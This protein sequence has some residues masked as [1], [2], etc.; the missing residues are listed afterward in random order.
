MLA[1]PEPVALEHRRARHRGAGD[2]V[3]RFHRLAAGRRA[4][5]APSAAA[6]ARARSRRA[7]P[8]RRPR[9]RETGPVGLDQRGRDRA[10]TDDEQPPRVGPREQ[11]R[12][13]E[14]VRRR[15]SRVT[16]PQSITA[17]SRPLPSS[18]RRSAPCTLGRPRAALPGTTVKVLR[19]RPS[20]RS[21]RRAT[22]ASRRRASGRGR[23]SAAAGRDGPRRAR[24]P[25]APVEPVLDVPRGEEGDG[26]VTPTAA[27]AL[28]SR[29]S[30]S[31]GSPA[32]LI[33]LSPTM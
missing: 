11:P 3:G 16:R 23:R 7:V 2:D 8:D 18:N 31:A 14:R 4:A 15:S 13:E 10:G 20:R 19:R 28:A 9:S 5:S 12:A 33:R 24:R 27:I 21:R 26:V 1:R 29:P 22:A 6:S 17:S 32:T 30:P 25:G